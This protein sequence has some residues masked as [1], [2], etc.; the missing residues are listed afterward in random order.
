MSYG[1]ISHCMTQSSWRSSRSGSKTVEV[2]SVA[3]SFNMFPRT[4]SATFRRRT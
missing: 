2:R 3:T 1:D 4:T